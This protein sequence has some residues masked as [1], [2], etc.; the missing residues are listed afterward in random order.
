MLPELS[1]VPIKAKVDTG[2]ATS[3]LHAFR[4]K[5]DEER[6][7]ASF[8]LHPLQR[9]RQH[10][11]RVEVPITGFKRVRSSSG[12][13][14]R[15]PVVRLTA[16]I[17]TRSHDIDVTLASRDEMGFR[18]LLG[19]AALRRRFVVDPSRSYVQAVPKSEEDPG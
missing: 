1:P 7:L 14:Q 8:E 3:S 13:A 5:V 10:A 17:G 4:L 12:H 18:M 19:R 6:S 15:R 11:I 2:A 16:R 9:S